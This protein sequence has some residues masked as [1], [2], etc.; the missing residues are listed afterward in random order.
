MLCLTDED[1]Y[2]DEDEDDPDALKDP[3]YQIDIQVTQGYFSCVVR[4]GV[5]PIPHTSVC[6]LGFV[7]LFMIMLDLQLG[8]QGGALK[9]QH[10]Q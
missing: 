7:N 4:V 6:L 1:Y 10:H 2:E 5:L 9:K 8:S 3:L